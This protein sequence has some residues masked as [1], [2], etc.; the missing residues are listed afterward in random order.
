MSFHCVLM[1]NYKKGNL[2]TTKQIRLMK[3]PEESHYVAS[4]RRQF[5]FVLSHKEAI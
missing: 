4:K 3:A 5:C 2:M 1:Q